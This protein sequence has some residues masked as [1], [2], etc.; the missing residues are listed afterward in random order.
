MLRISRENKKGC[1]FWE[2][3]QDKKVDNCLKCHDFPCE[4]HNDPKEAIWAKQA[5]DMWKELG[6]TGVTFGG[7]RKELEETLRRRTRQRKV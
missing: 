2:C 7:K 4:T 6:K 5:V 3:T 1:V